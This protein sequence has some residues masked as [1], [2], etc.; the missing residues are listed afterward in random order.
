MVEEMTVLKILIAP[1]KRLKQRS[2]DCLV[3]YS[4]ISEWLQQRLIGLETIKH[5]RTE[6]EEIYKFKKLTTLFRK[7]M[8]KQARTQSRTSPILESIAGGAFV[9]VILISIYEIYQGNINSSIVMSF[10]AT[11]ALL[12][13]SIGKLGSYLNFI[14]EGKV[15]VERLANANRELALNKRNNFIENNLLSGKNSEKEVISLNNVSIVYPGKAKY[16]LVDFTYKFKKNKIYFIHGPSGSGK[17]TLL[18]SLL[19]L[20]PIKSGSI[21][22][23]LSSHKQ[24]SIGYMPQNVI[25]ASMSIYE[26]VSYPDKC[27]E[28]NRV[29]HALKSVCMYD[30]CLSL[31]NGLD[32]KLTAG[33]G[34]GVSG[35]QAQRLLLSRVFYHKYQLIVLDEA[36]SSLDLGVEKIIYRNLRKLVNDKKTTV[37]QVSHRLSTK[38]YCDY[39][40]FLKDSKLVYTRAI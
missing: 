25:M 31:P 3:E 36:S 35:G 12:G 34:S 13:Q 6:D 24:N 2:R 7:K 38:H 17:T 15:A 8:Y 18:K 39:E 1:D 40:L 10:F 23:Y 5:Y 11:S 37:I 32:T 28:K 22:Y 27:F 14:Q 29:I 30:F 9:A 16:C 21:N 20:L 4:Q 33:E 19:G 26:T